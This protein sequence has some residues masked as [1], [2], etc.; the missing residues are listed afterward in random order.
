M[1]LNPDTLSL[2]QAMDIPVWVRPSTLPVQVI[3]SATV[4]DYLFL[5]GKQGAFDKG[6][7]SEKFN[8]VQRLAKALNFE[9][10]SCVIAEFIEGLTL[11]DRIAY[12][13][14]SGFKKVMVFGKENS[15]FLAIEPKNSSQIAKLGNTN[16]KVACVPSI[17]AML[18]SADE[19]K[20][21]W[22]CLSAGFINE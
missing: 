6:D 22:R 16:I 15:H 20:E 14:E 4:C 18:V 9:F 5:V 17:E 12:I 2:L 21:A 10:E 19:K 11:E 8:L 1:N 7:K 13:L 3:K